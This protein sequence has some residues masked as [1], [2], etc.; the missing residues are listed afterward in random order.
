MH[1]H[2]AVRTKQRCSRFVC[3]L[4]SSSS[5]VRDVGNVGAVAV[6]IGGSIG[7]AVRGSVIDSRGV[8]DALLRRC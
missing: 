3:H 6:S 7:V 8:C 5:T 2:N 1:I 4:D